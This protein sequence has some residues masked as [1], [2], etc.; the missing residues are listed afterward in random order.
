MST[1]LKY[2]LVTQIAAENG[3][4]PYSTGIWTSLLSIVK[5]VHPEL[6]T[7]LVGK[8]RTAILKDW[9]AEWSE[10]SNVTFEM[11]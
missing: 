11:E 6:P 10:T 2:T 9:Q 7:P 1:K 5:D 8:A 4:N 3:L